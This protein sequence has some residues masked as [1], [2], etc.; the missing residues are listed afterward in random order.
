MDRSGLQRVIPIILILIIVV[1][2]VAALISLGRAMFSGGGGQQSPLPVNSGKQALTNTTADR[3]VRMTVRGPIVAQ[4]NFHSY[5]I[6]I[7][8][9]K[10]N[11]TTYTGYIGQQVD[12]EALDNNVQAY[13]QFVNAL[14]RAKLMDGTPLSGDANSTQGVCATGLLYEFEVLQGDNSVQKLWTATCKGSA[15]SL[16]ANL[17]QVTSLFQRQIPDFRKL[18]DKV[19][20]SY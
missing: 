9:S 3:S 18:A 16:D 4:E 14:S 15:G 10:R 17:G 11:M 2:A 20:L 12:N 13:T 8:P 6:T 1:V 19:N 5:T 7:A